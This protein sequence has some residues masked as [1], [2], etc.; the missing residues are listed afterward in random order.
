M[1]RFGIVPC[2][3]LKLR[4]EMRL[5]LRGGFA[6]ATPANEDVA[7]H[8]T[9]ELVAEALDVALA[10]HLGA[11]VDL[12]EKAITLHPAQTPIVRIA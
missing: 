12:G 11:R 9:V 4:S 5:E 10:A 8:G 3:C 6:V 1:P 2:P 7:G